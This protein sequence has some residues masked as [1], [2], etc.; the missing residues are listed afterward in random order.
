MSRNGTPDEGTALDVEAPDDLASP[1]DQGAEPA[2]E[3]QA[4]TTQPRLDDP[5]LIQRAFTQS[6][7]KWAD[8]RKGLG[9]P[10]DAT[11]DDVMAAIAERTA[12]ASDDDEEPAE[13]M[14]PAAVLEAEARAEAA[15]WRYYAAIYPDTAIAARE[16]AEFARTEKDPETL[17]LKFYEILNRFTEQGQELPSGE[18]G[19]GA[20]AAAGEVIEGRSSAIDV[21][22]GDSPAADINQEDAAALERLRGSGR[23]AEGLRH[24][25]GWNRMMGTPGAT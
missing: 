13:A 22:V 23:V 4:A 19:D 17:T 3:L 1:E 8:L 24:I 15:E 5:A 2:E 12:P 6:Q 9:L 16:F 25:P 10:K 7:Q 20:E 14:S 18:P 11:P 21:G